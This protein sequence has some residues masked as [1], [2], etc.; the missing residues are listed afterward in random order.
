MNFGTDRKLSFQYL[1]DWYTI[2][3]V[4]LARLNVGDSL[5]LDELVCFYFH[6]A[7][8]TPIDLCTKETLARFYFGVREILSEKSE[9]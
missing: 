2:K 5:V 8:F 4:I 1:W 3:V 7:E 9:N 6:G